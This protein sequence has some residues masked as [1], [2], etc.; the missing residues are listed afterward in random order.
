[1]IRQGLSDHIAAVRGLALRMAGR[2]CMEG[3]ARFI[4]PTVITGII[5]FVVRT[6]GMFF[7][8][9]LHADVVP[10]RLC[11]VLAGRPIAAVTAFLAL[12]FA[13]G[14]TLRIA[15]SIDRTP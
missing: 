7:D 14:V 2:G 10:R 8:I 3:K 1:L 12:P 5:A 11:A 13:C 15:G 4:F 6:V 9:G